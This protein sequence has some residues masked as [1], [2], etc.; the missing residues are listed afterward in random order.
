MVL[1]LEN[2]GNGDDSYM[3][4]HEILLDENMTSDPGIIVSFS[5]NPVHLGAGSLRTVP[6]SVKLPESTPARVPIAISFIMTSQGN[7]SVYSHEVIIFEVRQDHRWDFDLIHNGEEIN[8]TK[9][10]LAPGEERAISINA[11]NTGNL[12]DDI[13]LDLGTQIFPCLLYTSPSPRDQRGSRMPSS[14]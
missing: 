3:L 13:S 6:L 5:S 4:S 14:A 9:I 10:F 7:M 2:P 12:V 1:K 8:G 11:T